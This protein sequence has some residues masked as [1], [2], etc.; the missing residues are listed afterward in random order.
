[1]ATSISNV[2]GTFGYNNSL[3][4]SGSGFG[5]KSRSKPLSYADFQNGALTP[6]SS[7]STNTAFDGIQNYSYVSSS[8]KRWGNGGL[9]SATWARNGTSGGRSSTLQVQTN[10]GLSNRDLFVFSYRKWLNRDTSGNWKTFRVWPPDGAS[11]PDGY[12]GCGNIDPAAN[13]AWVWALENQ[14]FTEGLNHVWMSPGLTLAPSSTWRSE[15][16]VL[17]HNSTYAGSD[18]SIY[19][20]F[21]GPAGN[22]PANDT[23]FS[24]TFPTS[25]QTA[26]RVYHQDTKANS[27]P[28]GTMNSFTSDLYVDDSFN[29]VFMGDAATWA[30]C[31]HVEIQPFSSWANGSVVITQRPGTFSSGTGTYLYVMDT[32]FSPNST[33]YQLNNLNQSPNPPTLTSVSPS[34]G[35]AAGGKAF[36]GTCTGLTAS[37][38]GVTIGGTA[39]TSVVRVSP[40]S[41]TAVAPAKA[42][43]TYDVVV[44]DNDAT[45]GTLTNGWTSVAAPFVTSC[46]FQASTSPFS[47]SSAST[48]NPIPH[49]QTVTSGYGPLN[50]IVNGTGFQPGATVALKAVPFGSSIPATNIRFISSTQLIVDITGDLPGSPNV[51]TVTNPDGQISDPNSGLIPCDITWIHV[52]GP[53]PVGGD[54]LYTDSFAFIADPDVSAF[55]LT[56]DGTPVAASFAAGQPPAGYKIKQI[57][58]KAPPL[59]SGA[60]TLSLAVVSHGS[61]TATGYYILHRD[62]IGIF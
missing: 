22:V 59:V 29:Q 19:I 51:V 46:A 37:L 34:S 61:A 21:D 57:L 14:T 55:T 24:Y 9:C 5:T 1:M 44:I 50:V 12:I 36:T 33:G 58:F 43:G 45:T 27:D 53:L 15:M 49:W 17:R 30:A 23:G 39:C 28:N 35:A 38:N 52:V 56:I 16:Y 48:Y 7:V 20:A 41:F 6:N 10:W 26:S 4:I 42:V 47:A 62:Q 11:Y 60:V 8:E 2:T 31:S 40:T 3:T 54:G 13:T 18:G 25:T 32:N